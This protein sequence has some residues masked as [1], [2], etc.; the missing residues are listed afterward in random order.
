MEASKA[1]NSDRKSGIASFIAL[2]VESFPGA[3]RPDYFSLTGAD[4]SCLI[5][6]D[7]QLAEFDQIQSL[8]TLL[9]SENLIAANYYFDGRYSYFY[10]VR[11]TLT[12]Y[13]KLRRLDTSGRVTKENLWD[14]LLDGH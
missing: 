3:L 6:T 7:D 9:L 13:A 5:L 10:N 4:Q 11:L 2:L 12:G 8:A 14:V 1:D